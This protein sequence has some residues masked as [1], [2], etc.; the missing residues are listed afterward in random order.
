M[1]FVTYPDFLNAKFYNNGS[2]FKEMFETYETKFGVKIYFAAF[3][4][5]DRVIPEFF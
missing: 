5:R 4:K 1:Q 2:K 3:R